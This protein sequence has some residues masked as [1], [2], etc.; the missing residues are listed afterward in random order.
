MTCPESVVN[1]WLQS[2]FSVLAGVLARDGM[3]LRAS[4]MHLV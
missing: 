4:A 3:A 1:S 2:V